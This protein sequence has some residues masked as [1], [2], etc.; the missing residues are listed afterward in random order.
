VFTR[1]RHWITPD[2]DEWITLPYLTCLIIYFI[3]TLSSILWSRRCSLIFGRTKML[4]TVAYRPVARRRPRHRR[5]PCKQHRGMTF[6]AR[7]AKR[8]LDSNRGTVFS[9]RSV[10]RCYKQNNWSN[11]LLVG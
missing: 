2:P 8:T 7:S 11:E 5:P 10:P 4:Y 9:V 6:S 1:A 3:V